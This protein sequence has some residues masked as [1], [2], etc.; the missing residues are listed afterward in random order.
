M[1]CHLTRSFVDIDDSLDCSQVDVTAMH[2]TGK[3][4]VIPKVRLAWSL[5]E[6]KQHMFRLHGIGAKNETV[7]FNGKKLDFDR[8]LRQQG[9]QHKSIIVVDGKRENNLDLPA[10]EKLDFWAGL[11]ALPTFLSGSISI[12]IRHWLGYEFVV[13]A[14]PTHYLDDVKELIFDQRKIP[15]D[16]QRITYKGFPVDETESLGDQGIANG[17]VFQLEPM[18]ISVS[19][20]STGGQA[21]LVVES[22]DT[23]RD[24]KKQ[25]F[26]RM[27]VPTELQCIMFGGEELSNS[28]TLQECSVDHEDVLQLEE[29]TVSIMHWLGDVFRLKGIRPESTIGEVKQ[30]ILRFRYVPKKQQSLL[31]KGKTL[32]DN[33]TLADELV[34]HKSVL[35]LEEKIEAPTSEQ[36]R[37]L[38]NFMA[39]LDATATSAQEDIDG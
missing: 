7:L 21:V 11:G 26:K 22:D 30:E 35:I 29:F 8:T 2:W 34:S 17:C 23:I 25:I 37:R 24:V 36:P 32:Q 31:Y 33:K 5:T 9:L 12:K 15:V 14:L 20:P 4:L 10:A 1:R 28:K 3:D 13:G 39:G 16:Q 18:K 6:L 19:Q 38:F 27:S